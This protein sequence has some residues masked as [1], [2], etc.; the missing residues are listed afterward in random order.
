M[1]KEISNW[2]KEK[3][4][5][6]QKSRVEGTKE[7]MRK[8]QAEFDEYIRA[9]KAEKLRQVAE[10]E[11]EYKFLKEKIGSRDEL[12]TVTPN[13]NIFFNKISLFYKPLSFT[14]LIR[15][16]LNYKNINFD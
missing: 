9:E 4:E 16:S 8:I 5:W 10:F 14:P 11:E 15:S 12:Q 7:E 2:I 3:T 13:V 6:L 1:I